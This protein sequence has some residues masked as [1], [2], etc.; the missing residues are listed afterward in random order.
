M[1]KKSE[2]GNTRAQNPL[3]SKHRKN[4]RK[5]ERAKSNSNVEQ[6][7]CRMLNA[8]DKEEGLGPRGSDVSCL[9]FCV[10]GSASRVLFAFRVARTFTKAN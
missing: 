10:L 3:F 6:A 5:M 7:G 1:S 8:G 9:G 4:G 2:F